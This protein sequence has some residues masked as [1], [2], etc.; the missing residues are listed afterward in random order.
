M[1][2]FLALK[3]EA[4][5]LAGR[6]SEALRAIKEAQ[7]LVET[8]GERCLAAELSRLQGIF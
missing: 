1:P 3:P 8:S 6:T 2:L 5:D 7:A 4:L